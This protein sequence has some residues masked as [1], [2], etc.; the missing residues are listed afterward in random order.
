VDDGLRTPRLDRAGGAAHRGIADACG[1]GARRR[2]ERTGRPVAGLKLLTA[3]PRA[4][5]RAPRPLEAGRRQHLGRVDHGAVLI[6]VGHG[7]HVSGD[8]KSSPSA[9]LGSATASIRATRGRHHSSA[10]LTIFLNYA[11]KIPSKIMT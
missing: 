1:P 7:I 10:H 9:L 2:P 5:E 8:T 6:Q 11:F 3:V 4:P